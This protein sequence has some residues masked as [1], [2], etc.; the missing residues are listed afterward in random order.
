MNVMLA[1]SDV[2]RRK[3]V[4]GAVLV[5]LGLPLALALGEAVRFHI[6]NRDTGT[7]VSS[8]ETREYLLYVPKSYDR[9]KP[10]PLVISLHGAGMWGAAQMETSQWNR[11]ADTQGFIV[12][13]PSGTK[14]HGPRAWHERED[15]KSTRLNSS[16][17]QKSRMPS[18]A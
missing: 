18:S 8:G 1:R 7:I 15:R 2:R 14:G 6:A 11:V 17:I 13:Y 9:S 16:H 12:V 3:G 4:I 10:T 5:F